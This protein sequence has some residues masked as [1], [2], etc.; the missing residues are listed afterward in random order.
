MGNDASSNAAGRTQ[1]F[2]WAWVVISVFVYLGIELLLGGLV[3]RLVLGRYVTQMMH[4][5]MQVLLNLV[6]YFIG[7]LA[8]GIVSPGIRIWEPAV[9]AFISVALVLAFAFF[10]PYTFIQ[11]STSKLLIG[12]GI[13]FGLAFVG[14]RLGEKLTGQIPDDE[15]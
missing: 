3:G 15:E 10:T 2:S 11:M 1:P 6:S 4:L 12:G 14:A 8:V 13:A 7:G 9:G 5:R